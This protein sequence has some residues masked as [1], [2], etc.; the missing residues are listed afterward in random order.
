[1]IEMSLTSGIKLLLIHVYSGMWEVSFLSFVASSTG[2][3]NIPFSNPWTVS[4]LSESQQKEVSK[5]VW[6][7]EDRDRQLE[8]FF[9][10]P[11][12]G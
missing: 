4:E 12:K 10:L 5:V 3:S 8:V 9:K 11:D 7:P 1:M 6:A 2:K